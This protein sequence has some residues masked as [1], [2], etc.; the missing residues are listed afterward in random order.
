MLVEWFYAHILIKHAHTHT[1]NMHARTNGHLI[2]LYM[3]IHT[4][5]HTYTC[6]YIHMSIYTHVHTYTYRTCMYLIHDQEL[7]VFCS[8]ECFWPTQRILKPSWR[9]HN[10]VCTVGFESLCLCMQMYIYIYKYIYTYIYTYILIY[11][12]IYIYMCV[13]VCVCVCV[14][15]CAGVHPP[16]SRLH[17]WF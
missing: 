5:V 6:A 8:Q 9:P 3:C 15:A 13:C 12:Y 17:R 2:S 7:Q 4:H 10:H 1:H 14:C 16:R 11:I